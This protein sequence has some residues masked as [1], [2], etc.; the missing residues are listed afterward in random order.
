MKSHKTRNTPKKLIKFL[1][2]WPVLTVL[3]FTIAFLISFLLKLFSEVSGLFMFLAMLSGVFSTIIVGKTYQKIGIPL[4]LELR[5]RSII[6]YL[7][8]SIILG[9]YDLIALKTSYLFISIWI[10]IIVNIL[11]G[12][13]MYATLYIYSLDRRLYKELYQT[14]KKEFEEKEGKKE[15]D[16]KTQTIKS[17]EIKI[18]TNKSK[19]I[20]KK[21]S[22]K[23]LVK[24]SKK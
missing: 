5:R 11:I 1:N 20:K 8:L 9:I 13:M 10:I 4:T 19:E 6:A 18:K 21:V 24:R 14:R 22:N 15:K 12:F 3:L 16:S 2:N 7:L 23:K 17:K